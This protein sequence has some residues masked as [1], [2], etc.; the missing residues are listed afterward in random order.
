[1]KDIGIKKLLHI[2]ENL[3]PDVK[4]SEFVNK[5][6]KY[7]PLKVIKNKKY[8]TAKITF[9]FAKKYVIHTKKLAGGEQTSNN[10]TFLY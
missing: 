10:N 5:K 3:I 8:F 9:S 1:M 4:N 2:H 6:K 7:P